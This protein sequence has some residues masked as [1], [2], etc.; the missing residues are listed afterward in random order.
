[1]LLLIAFHNSFDRILVNVLSKLLAVFNTII[2]CV[3]WFYVHDVFVPHLPVFSV[4]D[5]GDP[6]F[7]LRGYGGQAENGGRL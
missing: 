6:A 3:I 5:N 2:F 7:A 1:M 4:D